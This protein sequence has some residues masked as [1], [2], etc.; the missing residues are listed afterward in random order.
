MI[1]GFFIYIYIL[2]G[3]LVL[4]FDTTQRSE[5]T[6]TR[7]FNFVYVIL[8]LIAAFSYGVGN[9]TYAYKMEL[10]EV[11]TLENISLKD[12]IETRYQPL[13]IV[14]CSLCR[15]IYDDLLILQLLQVFLVYH[16]FYLVLRK[17]GLRKFWVLFL[18]FGY[19][20]IALLSARR[21][22]FGLAFCFY[23]MLFYMDRKWMPYYV[24]IVL[25]FLCHSGMFIFAA[26]PMVCVFGKKRFL[27]LLVIFTIVY[28]IQFSFQY[29]HVFEEIVNEN[30]SIMRYSLEDDNRHLDAAAIIL[31]VVELFI[32]IRY[33]LWNGNFQSEEID[34][35]LIYIGLLH[36]ALGFLSTVIPII[37]RYRTHFSI[38]LFFTLKACFSGANRNKIVVAFIFLV[39]SYSPIV[40]FIYSCNNHPLAYY[41]CSYFSSEQSKAEM[42][43]LAAKIYWKDRAIK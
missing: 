2:L 1:P 3:I 16:S 35:N 13:F 8:A 11:P 24:L 27:N 28:L 4:Y 25:G 23:A 34:I 21:E 41:Y 7:L 43:V 22:S 10:H 29:L 5:A 19:C 18:F 9:D 37:Y 15:T 14:I 42:D 26:F 30:D 40:T 38:F 32:I 31:I 6:Y 17:L 20:F 12:F 36:V 33:A 39:F